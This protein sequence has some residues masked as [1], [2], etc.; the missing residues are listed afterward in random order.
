METIIVTGGAGYIG[1]HTIIELLNKTI[2]Q[3]VS[4]DNYSNSSQDSYSRISALTSRPFETIQVD[5]CDQVLLN[6]KLSNYSNI[7]GIIHFAAFKSVSDSISDPIK[8]YH[9]NIN[10]LNNILD[11]AKQ[12]NVLNFIF[13]SSCSVY[14]NSKDLPVTENT[15]LQKAES[16]YA[17]TKQ[18]SEEIISFFCK[19]NPSFK[20]V[21]LRY[22]NPVGAHPSGKNGEF[23]IN[24]PNNLVPIITQTAIGKN[25]LTVFG[26][27]YNTRD[28]SC[29]RDYIHVCDIADAHLKA[30]NYLIQHHEKKQCSLF[31]LGTGNGVSVLEA[32]K[33]FEKITNQKLHYKIG[34]RRTGDV[35]AIYANNE[36]AKTELNWIPQYNI[37]DMMLSAWKWENHLEEQNA[38]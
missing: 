10:S 17:H 23:P 22:F 16:P 37:D 31:N 18:I 20:T 29:I 35:I 36:L 11:F 14:G 13:S 15:P 33:S 3:I 2:F 26:N 19:T 9:N 30:L 6:Q 24:I 27:D 4:I 12:K 34:E 38:K 5:L 7:I 21:L 8:Y 32:I 28:G 1:S 25:S